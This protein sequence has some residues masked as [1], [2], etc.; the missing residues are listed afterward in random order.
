MKDSARV[1][2]CVYESLEIH[3]LTQLLIICLLASWSVIKI[4]VSFIRLYVKEK[5]IFRGV[6]F[7]SH[8]TAPAMQIFSNHF[9]EKIQIQEFILWKFMSNWR[10]FREKNTSLFMFKI[11]NCFFYWTAMKFFSIAP[12]L[13]KWEGSIPIKVYC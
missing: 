4:F 3:L 13:L 9:F 2:V 5:S 10:L 11:F 7:T 1:C 6:E 12:K 8:S